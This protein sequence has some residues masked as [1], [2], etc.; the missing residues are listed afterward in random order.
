[1]KTKY[2]IRKKKQINFIFFFANIDPELA[3]Q[4]QMRQG[5]LT[6]F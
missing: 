6:V 4:Y 1:M 2:I 3:R 5:H